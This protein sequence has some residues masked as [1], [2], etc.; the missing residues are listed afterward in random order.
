MSQEKLYSLA[1]LSTESQ[2]ARKLDFKDLISD[3]AN[4][5]GRRWAFSEIG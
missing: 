5:K 1:M 4:E 2:L 3:F